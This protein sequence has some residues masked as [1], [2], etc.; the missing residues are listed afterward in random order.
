MRLSIK[1]CER[2]LALVWFLPSAMLV[3]ILVIQSLCNKYGSLTSDVW[4][5]FFPNL[6]PVLGLMIGV[7]VVEATGKGPSQKRIDP[8]YYR[9]TLSWSVFYQV[10]FALPILLLPFLTVQPQEMVDTLKLSN[11]WLA[12][13][14]GAASALLGIFFVKRET[15]A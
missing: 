4:Q 7:F 10:V 11:F 2:R 14:Q 5:W 6:T 15:D 12:P 1:K 3:L 13:M 9:L 8:F